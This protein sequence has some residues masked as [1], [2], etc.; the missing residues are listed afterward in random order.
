M[1]FS[2]FESGINC[3]QNPPF[4][5][6]SP[7]NSSDQIGHVNEVTFSRSM[8]RDVDRTNSTPRTRTGETIG[9]G[10]PDSVTGAQGFHRVVIGIGCH[11]ES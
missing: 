3:P 4:P 1:W 5:M 2:L 11:T 7:E 10:C 6:D 9:A 8:G